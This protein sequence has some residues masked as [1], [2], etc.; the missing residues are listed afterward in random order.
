MQPVWPRA[1]SISKHDAFN[2]HVKV[3]RLLP[4]YKGSHG[5]Y[6][7]FKDIVNATVFLNGIYNEVTL[8]DDKA[9]ELAQSLWLEVES[10]TKCRE[11][12]L[13]CFIEYLELINS[14][15]KGFL[16]ELVQGSDGN[17]QSERK[18]C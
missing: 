7:R 2:I 5:D 3:M 12:G 15:A 11:D 1:K 9:Y 14:K 4:I 13:F 10:T 8:D 6:K 18:N 16:Y 17:S